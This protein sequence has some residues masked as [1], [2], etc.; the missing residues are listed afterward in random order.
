[1][2]SWTTQQMQYQPQ[3]QMQMQLMQM[4]Q[5]QQQMLQQMQAQQAQRAQQQ[6]HQPW[7]MARRAHLHSLSLRYSGNV[8]D[9]ESG[10]IWHRVNEPVLS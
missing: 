10:S 7:P 3:M 5:V 9:S 1:M 8:L 6:P 4:H 2:K